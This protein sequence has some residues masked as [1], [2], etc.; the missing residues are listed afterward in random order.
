MQ[1]ASSNRS[2]T[3][4]SGMSVRVA[5]RGPRRSAPSINGEADLHRHL[6]VGDHAVLHVAAGAQHLEPADV[7]DAF[8]R[9][10][11][12]DADGV[13]AALG[14]GTGEFDGLVDVLGHGVLPGSGASRL[15][16]GC[17]RVNTGKKEPRW[18]GAKGVC[19]GESQLRNS[20]AL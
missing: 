6:P 18:A 16:P 12:G 5:I 17:G 1:T 15:A 2:M 11:Q 3:L 19:K 9:L 4:S 14:R 8:G 7:A 10:G 20:T 13:V